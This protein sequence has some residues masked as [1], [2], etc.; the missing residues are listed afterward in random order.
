MIEWIKKK[1]GITA[2]ENGQK[3]LDARLLWHKDFVNSKVAELKEYTRVDA[4]VGFRSNN[5][6]IL[7]G[8]YKKKAYVHFYDIGDGE[9]IR[10]VEQL[11]SMRGH[12]LLR[13]IDTPPMFKGTFDL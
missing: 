4:D 12:A 9:F 3:S 11:K 1:L 6:I 5:T 2:L 8:V 10:L 7:T 13:T